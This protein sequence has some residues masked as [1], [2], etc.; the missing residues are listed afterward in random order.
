MTEISEK[1]C[2]KL[3][4]SGPSFNGTPPLDPEGLKQLEAAREATRREQGEAYAIYILDRA[5]IATELANRV[6]SRPQLTHLD[7][8]SQ[9]FLNSSRPRKSSQ[10]ASSSTAQRSRRE[11]PRDTRQVRRRT[12][13]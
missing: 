1:R 4:R 11:L 10:C 6:I 5:N 9:D 3:G 7:A 12:T 8:H 13:S 2:R